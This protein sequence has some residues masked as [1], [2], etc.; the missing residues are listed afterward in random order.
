MHIPFATWDIIFTEYSASGGDFE[1]QVSQII[2]LSMQ[3][4][5]IHLV[6][7]LMLLIH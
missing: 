7:I 4:I 6:F 2:N 3:L 1:T 5:Q